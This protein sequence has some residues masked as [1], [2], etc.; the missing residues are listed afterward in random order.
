MITTLRWRRAAGR[1]TLRRLCAAAALTLCGLLGTTG[2]AD[3]QV[4]PPAPDRLWGGCQ[5]PALFTVPGVGDFDYLVVYSLI[6]NDGQPFYTPPSGGNPARID[7]TGPI[8]CTAQGVSIQST[9]EAVDI[10]TTEIRPS[11]LGTAIRYREG[12]GFGTRFKK[13]L[14]HQILDKTE[15]HVVEAL[16]S[17]GCTIPQAQYLEIRQAIAQAITLPAASPVPIG[18]SVAAFYKLGSSDPP[19]LCGTTVPT[20]GSFPPVV[21]RLTG[22]VADQA[23]AGSSL[24]VL[25]AENISALNYTTSG[26]KPETRLCH[27]VA[28]RT[29]C[30]RIYK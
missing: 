6:E 15:C 24:Q 26:S 12:T 2:A 25:D 10:P 13:Q 9:S 17:G 20:I 30:F 28:D 7:F 18:F 1:R 3:A 11:V 21:H 4:A 23:L 29:D 27:S 8:V 19:R 5:L 22:P 14:C 16:A